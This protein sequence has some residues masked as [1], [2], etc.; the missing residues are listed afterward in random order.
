MSNLLNKAKLTVSD[1]FDRASQVLEVSGLNPQVF[2]MQFAVYRNYSNDA[3]TLLQAST[4]ESKSAPLRVFMN[5]IGPDGGWGNEAIEM[6]LW[7]VNREMEQGLVTQVILIGDAPPNTPEE[8]HQKRSH[9]GEA[10]W[11][12]TSRIC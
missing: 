1:M 9:F 4:W 8:V 12:A 2:E 10:Y 11:R 7:H 6:G 5:T 3:D